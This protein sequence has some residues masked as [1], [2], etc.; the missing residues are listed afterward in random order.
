MSNLIGSFDFSDESA[1]YLSNAEYG[2]HQSNIETYYNKGEK[3]V[4]QILSETVPNASTHSWDGSVSFY[5]FPWNRNPRISNK[6]GYMW[7]DLN[8]GEKY[9]GRPPYGQL[10]YKNGKLIETDSIDFIRN[11]YEYF[12]K[13]GRTYCEG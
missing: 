13:N 10:E 9:P 4:S 8:N 6:Q 3:N 2:K 12:D 5:N 1:L 11:N 7:N